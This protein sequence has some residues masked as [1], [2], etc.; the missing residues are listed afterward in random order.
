MKKVLLSL[1]VVGAAGS[2]AVAGTWSAFSSTTGSTGNS[3]SAG[4]VHLT[5]NDV[6]AAMLS[7]SNARPGD[8]T[9]GCILVTYGGTLD[10][11]VKLHASVSGA[12][13]PYLTLTVTRGTDSSPAF[14]SCAS[15]TP[16]LT[17]YLGAGAGIVYSGLLS[18]FPASWAAG[19]VDVD[20]TWT[21]GETRSYRL[22]VELVDD[23][24]AENKTATA[25]FTWEAR[26]Q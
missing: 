14:S 22:R 26:N 19:L 25:T 23:E 15:F 13:A 5:D 1:L 21:A 10:A 12:L 24:A 17:D 7:L 16:D 9:T 4:T 8:S 6:G 11:A 3:F 2:A 18:A 20:G